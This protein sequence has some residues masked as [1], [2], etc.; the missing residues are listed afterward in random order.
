MR[1][2]NSKA[3]MDDGMNPELLDGA[4]LDQYYDI[5]IIFKPSEFII[6]TGFTP[7]PEIDQIPSSDELICFNI[8][9]EKFSDLLKTPD[10]FID[11]FRLGL[12]ILSPDC[13]MYTNAPL[14]A[15]LTNLYRNRVLGSYFQRKGI[16]VI[17]HVRW[18][19][20]RTY[21]ND[22]FKKPIAFCGIEQDSIISVS[23]YG[24]FN[25]N[26]EKDDFVCG[27]RWMFDFLNPRTVLVFGSME[28]RIFEPY[29][30]FAE[31]ICYPDW[32]ARKKRGLPGCMTDYTD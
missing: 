4:E 9:D 10:A 8:R 3:N 7:F 19:D 17:P 26:Q 24:C 31:L 18:G 15:Q 32:L 5:P 2:S 6:P 29:A 20:W 13:S 28:R 14:I 27:L 23:H 25:T 30:H 12:G 16:Y 11:K 1:K 22:V 21:T